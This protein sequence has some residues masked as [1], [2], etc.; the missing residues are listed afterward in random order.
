[1]TSSKPGEGTPNGTKTACPLI[2]G[3]KV[4]GL[5]AL[6]I[7]VLILSPSAPTPTSMYPPQQQISPS[8]DQQTFPFP[9]S[10]TNNI[11]PHAEEYP[12]ETPARNG[13]T[14]L[15]APIPV[16]YNPDGYVPSIHHA[17]EPD[18]HYWKNMFLEL[19]FGD[20]DLAQSSADSH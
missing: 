7:Y 2:P 13:A 6:R 9:T 8:H 15:S 18:A 16:N 14:P 10:P 5:L 3:Y 12:A 17:S 11:S 20:G 19:G 4:I 1:M